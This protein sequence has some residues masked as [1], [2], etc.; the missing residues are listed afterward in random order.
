M[1]S[2]DELF[3]LGFRVV[4]Q[5]FI[6]GAWVSEVEEGRREAEDDFYGSFDLLKHFIF[7]DDPSYHQYW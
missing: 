1:L 2:R 5:Y 3:G 4:G 6:F 7:L